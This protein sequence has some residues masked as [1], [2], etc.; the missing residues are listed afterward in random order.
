[1]KYRKISLIE[2]IAWLFRYVKPFLGAIIGIIL[3]SMFSSAL[4]V[5][6]AVLSKQ[7]VDSAIDGNTSKAIT[8]IIVFVI[9]QLI[10]MCVGAIT[11]RITL[12][13]SEKMTYRIHNDLLTSI[14]R[15][16]WLS[17]S[18]LHSG[19]ILTR[20]T[21]DVS[22]IV[23]LWTFTL[24]G[25]F[26]L[27]IQSI[28][29]FIVLLYYD[30]VLALFAFL[31]SPFS[32]LISFL[33]GMRIKK[34]QHLIQSAESIYRSYLTELVQNAYIIK[35]F[36]YER[37]SLL[38]VSRMQDE[39]YQFAVKRNNM[40]IASNLALSGGHYLGYA[41]AFVYGIYKLASQTIEFGT[42]TAFLQLVG[43]VQSPFIGLARSIPQLLSS[44]ASVERLVQIEK[45][46]EEPFCSEGEPILA[47][48]VGLSFEHV[49]FRYIPEKF[50]LRDASFHVNPGE[51]VGLIGSSGEG[52]TTI[53][54][55]LMGFL[56]PEEGEIY[57]TYDT[58][59]IRVSSGTRSFFSYVPQGNT[60]FSGTI[61]EN[62]ALGNPYAT[63]D[64][65]Y[66]ALQLADAVDFVNGL[67]KKIHTRI[68]ESGVGL[69]EGQAQRLCI[70]RALVRRA[71]ILLL[72]EATSA[73]DTDTERRI[74]QNIRQVENLSC[75]VITHRLSVLPLCD[76]VYS[77]EKGKL[78]RYESDDFSFITISGQELNNGEK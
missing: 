45:M 1:M 76:S 12:K 56:K 25:V 72:D 22:R 64:E 32:I 58:Q 63:E 41:L 42:F 5:G 4:G 23:S 10:I 67:D 40:G 60:L 62:L 16:N 33:L 59:N 66:T 6:S 78:H 7:M 8:Y 46:D 48:K 53:M 55:I 9:I 29:A 27:C 49:T 37:Q 74:F 34:L 18:K 44:M 26:S 43:Q 20:V 36:Q 31:I 19:D 39:K 21:D 77:L 13:L 30:S 61:A 73:L 24:P 65:M 11:S 71:P 2:N 14:F 35:S 70:A 51:I 50:I 38:N 47:Q 57:V 69:S 28:L 17:Y 54:R 68:G 75:I 52:K 3:I 15:K